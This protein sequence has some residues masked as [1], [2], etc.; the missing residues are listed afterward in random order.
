[1]FCTIVP[2]DSHSQNL[3]V[4]AM[5]SV[6]NEKEVYFLATV[7]IRPEDLAVQQ[8]FA[9]DLTLSYRE[10][11]K[12][13][14]YEFTYSIR[15]YGCQLN[16]SD[17]EK[18]SGILKSLS[19]VPGRT[20]D[21]DLV[22]YNTCS[23]RENAR[24]RL[25]GNLGLVKA[26]KRKNPSLIV[27]VCGCMMKQNENVEKIKK[28]YP[29]VD[30]IFGPQDIHR[31]PELLFRIR[32]QQKKVYDV[33]QTDYIADDLDLPIDRS[34]KFRAL[35][36]IMYGCN[37]FC[38]YCIVPYTRGRERSRPFDQIMKEITGLSAD[39]YK[40]ILLLGQNVNSY[41]RDLEGM[42]DFAD[43]LE[44]CSKVS[45]IVRVR[46][47]T[48]HPKDLSDRVIEIIA[49]N[50]TIEKHLHL[51]LQSGSDKILTAM[52]RHY[53]RDQYLRTARLFRNSV[54]QG[55]ISTDIIV[56]FPGETEDDFE[57]TLSLMREIRFDS[58]FTFQYSVRPGTPAAQMTDQISQ[59][60][61][62][63]RFS[64]LLEL[65]NGH[66]YESNMQVVG[67]LEEILIEGRSET[68][69][70]IL[71][72]RTGSNRLINFTLPDDIDLPD[73]SHLEKGD[74]FDGDKLEGCLAQVRI[75]GARPFSLEGRWESWNS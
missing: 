43:I 61:V 64:R 48:S 6:L 40:E 71:S 9:E 14:G 35:V 57:E 30:L 18:L 21:T 49:A 52:N 55:T 56:G 2:Q 74:T 3:G 63:E 13:R 22:I 65:Q 45:G 32:F 54:P 33:S 36:P 12:R 69:P 29:F 37:N 51:P 59:E 16:E 41:G 23:I 26:M 34:R 44:A 47:M 11:T 58:A 53:S 31:L 46:F 42:P 19:F 5:I 38:T 7:V 70:H 27:A 60:V 1:M 75:T 39:G 66:C 67:T 68:A 10:E 8:K 73:G 4:S 15:T 28:S 50:P 24:D 25:F 20:E 17:S 62:T 72:G